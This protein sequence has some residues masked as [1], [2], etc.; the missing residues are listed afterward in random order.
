MDKK[1]IKC[2]RRRNK[3]ILN[4]VKH[5][6]IRQKF[7]KIS[8]KFKKRLAICQRKLY[9]NDMER[10]TITIQNILNV[11]KTENNL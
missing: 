1:S 8:K 4:G 11:K 3:S 2:I 9:N 5:H 7:K 10:K 6:L